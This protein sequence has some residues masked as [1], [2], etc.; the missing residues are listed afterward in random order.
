MPELL[1]LALDTGMIHIGL[2]FNNIEMATLMLIDDIIA[3]SFDIS[4]F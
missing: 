3:M 4:P 1:I 2:A